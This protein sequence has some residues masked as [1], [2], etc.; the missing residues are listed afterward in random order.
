MPTRA[1]RFIITTRTNAGLPPELTSVVYYPLA[2]QRL[3]QIL[4]SNSRIYS[5]T[6]LHIFT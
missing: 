4:K 2:P 1:E 5:I 3:K 6:L